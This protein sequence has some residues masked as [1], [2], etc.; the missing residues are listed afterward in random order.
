MAKGLT[1]HMQ[2][3]KFVSS[4]TCWQGLKSTTPDIWA[5]R[6]YIFSLKLNFIYG[7]ND[8]QVAQHRDPF[9]VMAQHARLHSLSTYRHCAA[10]TLPC[11]SGKIRH[12]AKAILGFLAWCY[13][14]S[15]SSCAG[16][17]GVT[18]QLSF[19]CVS[20]HRSLIHVRSASCNTYNLADP[21]T[22]IP[23]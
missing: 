12:S 16:I 9:M 22:Q 14:V 8:P 20:L 2:S 3:G 7:H 1:W 23:P 15:D 18:G 17:G 13:P 19:N 6:L 5:R 4:A 11:S 10:C 21:C